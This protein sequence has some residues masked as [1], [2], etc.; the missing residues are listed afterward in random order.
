MLHNRGTNIKPMASLFSLSKSINFSS[1]SQSKVDIIMTGK[2][3][4]EPKNEYNQGE[5]LI[6]E[7][8]DGNQAQ[9]Q[10]KSII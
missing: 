7:M 4:S 8:Q 10:K 6:Q 9:K 3:S 2:D 5:V 1:W